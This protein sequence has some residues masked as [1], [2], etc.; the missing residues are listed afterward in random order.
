MLRRTVFC[1]RSQQVYL[2]FTW[3]FRPTARQKHGEDRMVGKA[4]H[5]MVPRKQRVRKRLVAAPIPQGRSAGIYFL[6]PGQLPSSHN[7]PITSASYECI[8][9]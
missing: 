2:R 6:W 4:A 9:P 8:N 3:C 1:E 5:F 7:L